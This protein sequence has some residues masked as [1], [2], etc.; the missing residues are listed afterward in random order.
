MRLR[1]IGARAHRAH[2]RTPLGDEEVIEERQRHRDQQ[3][4]KHDLEPGAVGVGAPHVSE[5]AG[6]GEERDI[7]ATHD[8]QID[9]VEH[10]EHENAGQKRVDAEAQMDERRRAASEKAAGGGGKHRGDR[11]EA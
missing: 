2:S 4:D 11:I 7:A 1:H 6:E 5:Q 9:A 10:G 8:S 3:A